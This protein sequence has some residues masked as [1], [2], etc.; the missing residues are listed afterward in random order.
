V[1]GVEGGGDLRDDSSGP[2]RLEATASPDQRGEVGAFDPAH[3][4]EQGAV[5]LARLV[6]RDD[7]RMVDRSGQARLTLK[8]FAEA[9]V[10]R[11][12]W[13]DELECYPP[14]KGELRGLVHD[15]HAPVPGD[16]F[17]PVAGDPRAG[18]DVD[19]LNRVSCVPTARFARRRALA[20][21]RACPATARGRR[22]TRHR[23]GRRPPPSGA[24]RGRVAAPRIREPTPSFESRYLRS[25]SAASPG[26]GAGNA[27]PNGREENQGEPTLHLGRLPPRAARRDDLGQTQLPTRRSG[28]QGGENA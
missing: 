16:A 21:G 13:R 10:I 11:E 19:H 4:Q 22:A 17:D 2:R 25:G 27:C 26:R 15:A 24:T 20:L 5:D 3:R 8:A 28:N 1:R 12:H 7:V 6:D 23:R 18:G 14:A 9:R